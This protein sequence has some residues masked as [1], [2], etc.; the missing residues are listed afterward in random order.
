MEHASCA[1]KDVKTTR[2]TAIATKCIKCDYSTECK[3]KTNEGNFLI[4]WL[5][6]FAISCEKKK[7]EQSK[8]ESAERMKSGRV[9][10][11]LLHILMELDYIQAH[12]TKAKNLNIYIWCCKF[13]T[14]LPVLDVFMFIYHMKSCRLDRFWISLVILLTSNLK[15]EFALFGK[16][17]FFKV[18][19]LMNEGQFL[20][21]I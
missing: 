17:I 2:A 19:L 1:L 20:L 6:I 3:D 11:D 21:Y 4:L 14:Y 10:V 18:L 8:G 12:L 13:G 5:F 16:T 9:M 7:K 15:W